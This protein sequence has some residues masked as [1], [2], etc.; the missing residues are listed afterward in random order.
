VSYGDT[1]RL[2]VSQ[3]LDRFDF[4]IGTVNRFRVHFVETD[5]RIIAFD[6]YNTFYRHGARGTAARERAQAGL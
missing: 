3:F 2:L 4:D 5:G 6:A 1:F